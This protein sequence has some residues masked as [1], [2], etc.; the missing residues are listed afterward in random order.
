MRRMRTGVVVVV[1]VTMR[2]LM[3]IVMGRGMGKYN[4]VITTRG[5]VRLDVVDGGGQL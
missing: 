5:G 1:A 3:V 2:V 4:R